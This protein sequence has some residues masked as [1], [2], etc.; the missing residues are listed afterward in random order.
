MELVC[1]KDFSTFLG[2]KD[3]WN[4][5]LSRSGSDSLFLSHEWLTSW[6]QS[7]YKKSQLFVLLAK[8]GSRII[9][10]APLMMLK[11]GTLWLPIKK[12]TFIG[13]S[14]W[15]TGDFI[16]AERR[17]EVLEEFAGF[18]SQN[19]WDIIDLRNIPEESENLAII[20]GFCN[21]EGIK[22][23]RHGASVSPFLHV[24]ESW[25][26]FYKGRSQKFRKVMRNKLN[27]ISKAGNFTIQ[28]YSDPKEIEK[29]VPV[30]FNIAL[31][32]WK[33]KKNTAISSNTE[34]KSF[35][36]LI[37]EIFGSLGLLNI[38]ILSV[39]DIP[40]AFEYHLR[41]KDK[42]HALLADYDETYDDLS[43]GSVL[44]YHI[45]QNILSEGNCIYDMGSGQNFY[46]LNWTN[47]TRKHVRFSFF[48]NTISGEL[49]YMGK[50]KII[51]FLK[52]L[53]I[54]LSFSKDKRIDNTM[55]QTGNYKVRIADIKEIQNSRDTWNKLALSMNIP[56]VF[57][58]WEWIN[59][60]WRYFGNK[61][62]PFILFIF[63]DEQLKGILPLAIT[64][65]MSTGNP[66]KG[67]MISF[68][69][70]KELSPDHLDI[71][72]SQEDAF[73]CIHAVSD[74]LIYA[75]KD[76]DILSV[77]SIS[78]DSNL[79][80]YFYKNGLFIDADIKQ[81]T[82]APYISI[83]GE[84]D[85]YM[86][87]FNRKQRY[88]IKSSRIKLYKD[89]GMRYESCEP[90][91]LAEGILRLFELHESRARQ[92]KITS[93]FTGEQLIGFHSSLVREISKKGWLWLKFLKN[94]DQ[95][96]AAFYGFVFGR[97]LFY[98]QMGFDPEWEKYS[99][100][101]VLLYE[102]IQEAFSKN[103]KEFDFLRGDE[104]Y[105]SRWA[106]N[107]RALYKFNVYNKTFI[108]NLSKTFSQSRE[109]LENRFK[110]MISE[111]IEDKNNVTNT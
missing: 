97:H 67:K 35:Y 22:Y 26:E 88:N 30:V 49:L 51:P 50:S 17:K 78:G 2:L 82:I 70:S 46:K 15:T 77:P 58:A 69:G 93:T 111:N 16:V 76:W 31:K 105:K 21:S 108:G 57:C 85:E 3:D 36:T 12:M 100:G 91:F 62:E 80:S 72:C 43:P 18:L 110:E 65:K 83:S 4:N 45:M 73:P 29:V 37:S 38:W 90:S 13:N 52:Q 101:T 23:L 55:F 48:R 1:I 11:K 41:Y 74:F 61:Y 39:N 6:C 34:N 87:F 68:C 98:Y 53:E 25:E 7:Y 89:H 96:I 54:A 28:R 59:I 104:T 95:I 32:G 42:I 86:K 33:Y 5:L 20:S 64:K 81:V 10:A 99:P 79:I 24:T 102:V 109:S 107:S 47:S 106:E 14:E 71:I 19:E 94:E 40:I 56:S 9:G 66:L 63:K 60:W 44:D 27:R 103:I 8:E 92:K 84:F 75:Y